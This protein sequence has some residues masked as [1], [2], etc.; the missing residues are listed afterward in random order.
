[1]TENKPWAEMTWHEK[2]EERF[3]QWLDAPGVQFVSAEA[4]KLYRERVTRFIK[5]VKLEEPDRVPV[6]LP[7]GSF[8]AYYAGSSF[9]KIMYDYEELKRVSIKFMDDFGD[10]DSFMAPVFTPPGRILDALDVKIMKW[11]GHGFGKD[12]PMQQI[13]EG[14]YMKADEYDRLMMDPTDYNLRV[15][16]P[17]TAGVFAP[18][19]KMPPLRN[20]FGA[21]SWVGLLTN[22]EIRKVFQ[23]LMDLSDE[24]MRHQS[25]I[26]EVANTAM[27]RG[28]PSLFGGV[29]AQAPYDFFA[30]MMRGTHGIA[31]DL[32]RQPDKLLEAIDVQLKLTIETTIKNFPMTQ[33]P[34]CM[35]PL[36]KGDDTFMSEEQFRKFYW[37]SLQKLF[38]AMIEEG[39]VPFPF[40]EGKY[41]SR[42]K[43]ITETP[44]TGVVWYFDQTDMA[45][46][47]KILGDVSCIVG[48]VPSSVI[49]TGTSAQVKENCR[50]LIET[51][52]P[53]GGYML[54]GGASVD[55]ADIANFRAMMEAAYEY[56]VYKK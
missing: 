9:Y 41:T 15:T 47:K 28:Y 53:G 19:A 14:E 22:P 40:A 56:G 43:L 37:P 44:R 11:P 6:M 50:R 29:M 55:T 38:V 42:L 32:Y 20:L 7:V 21:A 17:R 24:F 8:P 49:I 23:T 13:V 36:H 31:M 54:A 52:A 1:M 39:L 35:M 51:C 3:K 26:M 25:A 5:A 4:K 10:M 33:C 34:L 27:S 16:L 46:A 48:N 12:V 2:R 30:D 18:F 45:E